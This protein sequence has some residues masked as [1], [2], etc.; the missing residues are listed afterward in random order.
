MDGNNRWSIKNQKSKV[1]SYTKGAENLI[2]LANFIFTSTTATYVSAFALST[3]NLNR[4]ASIINLIKKIL[5]KFLDD[6]LNKNNLKFS[7]LF[8]GD[9]SFL[10]K[11]I[12]NKINLVEKKNISSK[13]KLIIFLNYS[14]RNDI[15]NTINKIIFLKLNKINYKNINSYL[16]TTNVPDPDILIRTGGFQRISDF[17][18]Y[19]ISFTELFFT[20]KLWPDLNKE[21]MRKIFNKYSF[22]QR[23]FGI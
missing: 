10:N 14:G 4:S 23:K 22:I 15:L 18:L 11:D 13:K 1:F 17:L 19:Q 8:K 9:L 2:K 5:N 7:I 16:S 6:E 3:N 21:D 20:K 12:Q